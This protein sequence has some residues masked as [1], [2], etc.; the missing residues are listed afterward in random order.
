MPIQL[1]ALHSILHASACVSKVREGDRENPNQT[2]LLIVRLGVDLALTLLPK[3]PQSRPKG[4]D[5]EVTIGVLRAR[6]NGI[7]NRY[8]YR[9]FVVGTN[10]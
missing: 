9:T 10:R 6:R 4:P 2:G 8:R 3:K 1:K 7:V 5:L